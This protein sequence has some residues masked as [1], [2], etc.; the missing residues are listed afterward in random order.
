ML[1]GIFDL[2]AP[3]GIQLPALSGLTATSALLILAL[4]GCSSNGTKHT[5]GVG[6]GASN[7][8]PRP[9]L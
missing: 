4:V 5:D 9:R 3:R 7:P 2:P 8:P 1:G 6:A